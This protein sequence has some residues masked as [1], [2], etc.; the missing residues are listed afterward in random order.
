MDLCRFSK[1]SLKAEL[2]QPGIDLHQN[3]RWFNNVQDGENKPSVIRLYPRHH[4]GDVGWKLKCA[5]TNSVIVPAKANTSKL[6]GVVVPV[7]IWEDNK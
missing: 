2:L 6:I 7:F 1:R 4:V 3:T 5:Q